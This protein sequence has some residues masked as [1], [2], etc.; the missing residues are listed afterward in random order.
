MSL[1]DEDSFIDNDDKASKVPRSWGTH[2]HTYD[3]ISKIL[4][5]CQSESSLINPSYKF[6]L[7]IKRSHTLKCLT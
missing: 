3:T 6:R 2:I 7:I 4:K 1:F 5:S